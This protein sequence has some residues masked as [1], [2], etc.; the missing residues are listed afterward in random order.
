MM[1]S[2]FSFALQVLV[3]QVKVLRVNIVRQHDQ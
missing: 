1:C 2:I 3:L